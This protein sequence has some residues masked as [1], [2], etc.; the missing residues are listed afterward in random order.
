MRSGSTRA[1][2]NIGNQVH[3]IT[4]KLKRASSCRR[5]THSIADIPQQA[6]RST[7]FTCLPAS[8]GCNAKSIDFFNALGGSPSAPI[9][10]V[11]TFEVQ[12]HRVA[13]QFRQGFPPRA[14]RLVRLNS[15]LN[16]VFHTHLCQRRCWTSVDSK[17]P[18]SCE[19]N[20][21]EVSVLIRHVS[22]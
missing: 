7:K 9:S 8:F 1:P 5:W 13:F 10:L 12:G 15:L 14:C 11:L 2:A 21:R 18:L 22:S 17:C 4:A 6:N 19:S 16:A 20:S 3:A